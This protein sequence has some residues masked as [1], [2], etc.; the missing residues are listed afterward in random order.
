MPLDKNE[1]NG[2]LNVYDVAEGGLA[3]ALFLQQALA[4]AFR[5]RAYR[6]WV[7]DRRALDAVVEAL[8]ASVI[9]SYQEDDQVGIVLDIADAT[10]FCFIK[11]MAESESELRLDVLAASR[12]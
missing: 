9:H 4:R 12:W 11:L 6:R 10:F 8:D 5:F 3:N 7:T 1:M 2:T